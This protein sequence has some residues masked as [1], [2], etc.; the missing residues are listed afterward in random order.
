MS[1]VTTESEE[2]PIEIVGQVRIVYLGPVEP[3]W[4][5]QPVWGDT[6]VIQEFQDRVRAR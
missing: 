2:E 6:D 1:Q 4:D 5:F 3:H